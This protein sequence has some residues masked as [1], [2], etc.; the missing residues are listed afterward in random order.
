V[1]RRAPGGSGG[2][3][4]VPGPGRSAAPPARRTSRTVAAPGRGRLAAMPEAPSVDVA[5]DAAAS[6]DDDR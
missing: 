3:V 4:V 6:R 2:T 5:L 1:A